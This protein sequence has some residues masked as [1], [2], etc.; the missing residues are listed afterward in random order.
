M[1]EAEKRRSKGPEYWRQVIDEWLKSGKNQKA[2]CE[3]REISLTTF[4]WWRHKL[5]HIDGSSNRKKPNRPKTSSPQFI[6][7]GI[8]PDRPTLSTSSLELYLPGDR[9]LRIPPGFD[10]MTLKQVLEVL[11]AASC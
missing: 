6:P 10:A 2:F 3:S 7:I 1:A 9:R 8:K 11:D 5:L 4:R